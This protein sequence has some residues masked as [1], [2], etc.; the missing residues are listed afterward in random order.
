MAVTRTDDY[1]DVFVEVSSLSSVTPR[2]RRTADRDSDRLIKLCNLLT[3]ASDDSLCLGQVEKKVVSDLPFGDCIGTCGECRQSGWWRRIDDCVQLCVVG[4]LVVLYS[5]R[6]YERCRPVSW[7]WRIAEVRGQSPA[8]R[9]RTTLSSKSGNWQRRQTV[10]ANSIRVQ[11]LENRT[12]EAE[13][14]LR[15]FQK[16]VMIKDIKRCTNV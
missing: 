3:R 8:V 2:T 14:V 9:R 11:S 5:E 7:R 10:R 4:E 15:S 12:V 1:C 6:G 16:T 13:E